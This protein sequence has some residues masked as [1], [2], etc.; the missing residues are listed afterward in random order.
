LSSAL[1]GARRA[2]IATSAVVIGAAA[3]SPIV[4]TTPA[5]D[6]LGQHLRGE[7]LPQRRVAGGQQDE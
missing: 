6:L 7:H 3:I 2:A 1:S 5:D 4:P